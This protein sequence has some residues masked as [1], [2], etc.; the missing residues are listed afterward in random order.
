MIW[1]PFSL[2]DSAALEKAFHSGIIILI[3]LYSNYDERTSVVI[4]LHIFSGLKN[5]MVA[6]DGGRYDVNVTERTRCPVYWPGEITNVR[7]CSWFF[8]AIDSRFMP[9]EEHISDLLE[10]H[11]SK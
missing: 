8:K 2:I 1:T 9:Y 10:V 11:N 4:N 3:F 6:T 5:A 7:R